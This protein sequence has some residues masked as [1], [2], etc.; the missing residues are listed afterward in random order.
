MISSLSINA[1]DEFG[2]KP[3]FVPAEALTP[4]PTPPD[5]RQ[6]AILTLVVEGEG[7][8]LKGIQLERG[9]IVNSYAPNVANRP[10]EWTV[11]VIGERS[12]RFGIDDPRRLHVYGSREDQREQ[13]HTTE[14]VGS[15]NFDLV[16]PLYD[17]DTDLQAKEIRILDQEGNV[18]FNTEVD[19]EGWSR[20]Q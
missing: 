9:Q 4:V 8:D 2:P 10:G 14:L 20:Q 18:I 13:A 19:R 17:L 11:E 5:G 3:T 16:V 12:L 1:Q 15:L 7:E 6:V